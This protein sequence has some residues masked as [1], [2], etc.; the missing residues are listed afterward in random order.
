MRRRALLALGASALFAAPRKPNIVVIVVDDLGWA[1]LGVHGCKDIPTPN[2]DSLAKNGVRFATGYS[3]GLSVAAEQI[4]LANR[5]KARGYATAAVD[6]DTEA[7]VFVDRRR[8]NPFFLSWTFAGF[9]TAA[10]KYTKKFA[11]SISDAKRRN[12]AGAVAA[13]DDGIGRLLFKLREHKIE[14]DTLLFFVGGKSG[15][16]VGS[17]FRGAHGSVF[18]GGIRVPF[19]VQWR[20]AIKPGAVV[21]HAV[22]GLDVFAT[23]VSAATGVGATDGDGVDLLPLLTLKSKAA[24]H[25]ALYWKLG[26]QQAVRKGSW[27]LVKSGEGKWQLY[28]LQADVGEQHNLASSMS[29]KREELEADFDEWHRKLTS[30]K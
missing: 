9:E 19:L 7:L 4:T 14:D 16:A 21:E 18:E 15:P 26:E 10:E 3:A 27:K 12:V 11:E 25:A 28:Q 24:P 22:S 6:A 29:E 5:L 23:A 1:D 2:I 30:G 13:M 8:N 17:P 20:G